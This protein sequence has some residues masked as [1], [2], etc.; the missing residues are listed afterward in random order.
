[1]IDSLKNL[2]LNL[3]EITS[4]LNKLFP[5]DFKFI[6]NILNSIQPL[7]KIFF[8]IYKILYNENDIQIDPITK[9]VVI[10]KEKDK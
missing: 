10:K 4:I 1:M 7:F 9:L 3:T 8:N 2:W 6:K 5:D